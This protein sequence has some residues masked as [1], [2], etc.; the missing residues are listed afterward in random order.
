LPVTVEHA[1]RAWA[2]YQAIIPH[3]MKVAGETVGVGRVIHDARALAR[4]L[5]DYAPTCPNHIFSKREAQRKSPVRDGGRLSEG[6]DYLV[7]AGWLA[8]AEVKGSHARRYVVPADSP[9]FATVAT[10]ATNEN[11]A[12]AT[13]DGNAKN[14]GSQ[15]VAEGC[16]KAATNSDKAAT[17]DPPPDAE[18][19]VSQTIAECRTSVAEDCDSD[20]PDGNAE[21]PESVASVASVAEK[22]DTAQPAHDLVLLDQARDAAHRAHLEQ[23]LAETR[24]RWR[25]RGASSAQ[26]YLRTGAADVRGGAISDWIEAEQPRQLA[27]LRNK[28]EAA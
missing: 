18:P 23:V 16:D 27:A 22:G 2:I 9:I 8:N 13:Y 25:V 5:A 10:V 20:M 12:G 24:R 4:W 19:Q 14:E 3:F 21:T 28:G 26:G 11:H 6:L 1:R 17:N 7:E 15:T